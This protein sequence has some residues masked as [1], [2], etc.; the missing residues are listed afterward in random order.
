MSCCDKTLWPKATL[1]RRGFISL[2]LP[3][4]SPSIIKGSRGTDLSK[5]LIT[6][7]K[8]AHWLTHRQSGHHGG[9]DCEPSSYILFSMGT[10]RKGGLPGKANMVFFEGKI[11]NLIFL[12]MFLCSRLKHIKW[13]SFHLKVSI[14][15]ENRG[16][17]VFIWGACGGSR[18]S[19]RLD[20]S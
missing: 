5:N 13:S 1:G 3:G 10:R 18:G 16:H 19:S 17:S 7:R 4:H 11:K 20:F 2:T 14:P 15:N 9:H 6:R 12:K 8:A